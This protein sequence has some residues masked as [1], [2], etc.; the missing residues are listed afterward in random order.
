[1]KPL[2]RTTK[3]SSAQLRAVE[4]RIG[5]PLPALLREIYTTVGGSLAFR[6]RFKKGMAKTFSAKGTWGAEPWGALVINP[7]EIVETRD[8]A[9][10]LA[11]GD[12]DNGRHYALDYAAAKKGPSVVSYDHEEIDDARKV[13]RTVEAFFEVLCARG[14]MHV[15]DDRRA[16]QVLRRGV[17]GGG[18]RMRIW[19]DPRSL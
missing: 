1:V 17:S 18:V 15:E 14:F 5:H 3:L 12:D 8:G 2:V 9:L 19:G 10:Y 7:P 6:W 11:F 4:K 16:R 13:A